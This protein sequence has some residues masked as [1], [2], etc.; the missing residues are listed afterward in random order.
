MDFGDKTIDLS[1]QSQVTRFNSIL[2]RELFEFL[3]QHTV[4]NK[5]RIETV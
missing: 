2:H 5:L 1:V 3:R 4:A